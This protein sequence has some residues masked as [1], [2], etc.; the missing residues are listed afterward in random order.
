VPSHL[1]TLGVHALRLAGRGETAYSEWL[2]RGAAG[3]PVFWGGAE[4]FTEARKQRLLSPMLRGQLAD[5]SSWDA[6]QPIHSRFKAKAWEPS[7]LHWM[8]YVDLNLRLP[9]LL[10]MR[11]DKMSMGVSLEARVPFLDHKV[12]ELAM[13]VPEAVK[14]RNGRLKHILKESVRG[15]IP[16]DLINRRKQGF[17]VPVN[18]WLLSDLGVRARRT[19]ETFC[20]ESGLLDRSAVADT[21][22][23]RPGEQSWCLFNLALWWNEYIRGTL[24][25]S[26]RLVAPVEI[27]STAD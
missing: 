26:T 18:E 8:S 23:S 17:G 9:E 19:V 10:L 25:T 16:D 11:V 4:V 14:T 21:M 6:L 13:S 24:T 3:L 7:A 1:K 5:L 12:V 20:D 2:R 22:A 27:A 15:L